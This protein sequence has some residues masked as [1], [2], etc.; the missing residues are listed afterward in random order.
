MVGKIPDFGHKQ[1]KGFGK[2][3]AHPFPIFLG[4]P[5]P[6]GGKVPGNEVASLLH[7]FDVKIIRLLKYWF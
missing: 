3:A 4:V 1:G 2:R 7:N 6:R 5:I